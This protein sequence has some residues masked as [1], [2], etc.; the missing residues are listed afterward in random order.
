MNLNKKTFAAVRHVVIKIEISSNCNSK[1]VSIAMPID[2]LKFDSNGF[3]Y[4]C[5]IKVVA[6]ETSSIFFILSLFIMIT[7]PKHMVFAI[8][9]QL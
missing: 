3:I 5:P 6:T 2:N 4:T 1:N 8:L 9:F 7:L